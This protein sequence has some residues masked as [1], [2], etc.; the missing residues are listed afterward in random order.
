L[1]K[2]K[3]KEE[4]KKENNVF[5]LFFF[6]LG[7]IFD[8]YE[9][10]FAVFG[11]FERVRLAL[12][13][14]HLSIVPIQ[15]IETTAEREY[16]KQNEYDKLHDVENHA[17]KRDLQRSQVRIYGEYVNEFQRA[18]HI[19]TG[20]YAFTDQGRIPWVPFFPVQ[21]VRLFAH[22]HFVL[23]YDERDEFE[24]NGGYV[25]RVGYEIQQIPP[26]V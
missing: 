21:L 2:K 20:E 13:K 26:V 3:F 24:H 1:R 19:G 6:L 4:K 7:E 25:K 5:K 14:T 11:R 22:F 9:T 23:N 16:D 18:E 10:L 17:T 12:L 15:L 8:F